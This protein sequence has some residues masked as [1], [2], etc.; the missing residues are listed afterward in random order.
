MNVNMTLSPYPKQLAICDFICHEKLLRLSHLSI[1][2]N[3]LGKK[4]T[5]HG[6]I[7][8]AYSAWTRKC[9]KMLL[10]EKMGTNPEKWHFVAFSSTAVSTFKYHFQ[11]LTSFCELIC[12]NCGQNCQLYC[13]F[14]NN[15]CNK[16]ATFLGISVCLL[17]GCLSNSNAWYCR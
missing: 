16:Q 4:S 8:K 3:I 15:L 2:N 14:K 13:T 1:L 11:N 17:A 6:T 5:S 10:W 9:H 7:S 12:N